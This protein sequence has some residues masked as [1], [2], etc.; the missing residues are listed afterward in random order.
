[1][2]GTN[3]SRGSHTQSWH[4]PQATE[5]FDALKM[6]AAL[7]GETQPNG[8][9]GPALKHLFREL[10]F[11]TSPLWNYRSPEEIAPAA[12]RRVVML[13]P[14]FGTHPARLKRMARHLEAAGH[15]VKRWGQGFNFGPTPENFELLSKRVLALH[16]SYGEKIVLVGWSLGGIFAREVAKCHPEAVAKVVTMGAPFSGSPKANNV[17]RVYHLITGHS[18]EN[19]PVVGNI[20]EKPPV[21]TTALW[22]ACD[23]I[24][25]P[26]SSRGRAGERDKAVALRCG[27]LGFAYSDEAIDAVLRELETL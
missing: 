21:P 17:W 9:R 26:R 11:L 15:T 4:A 22:S 8:V 13:L 5:L 10:Q 6:R 16:R 23:G 2:S 19:P 14:G 1:M 12:Q 20:S 3:R 7:V 18:V 25:S 27:H 24:V